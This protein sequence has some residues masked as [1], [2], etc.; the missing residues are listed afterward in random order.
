MNKKLIYI[1]GVFFAFVFIS[2][3]CTFA[4]NTVAPKTEKISVEAN[5]N[6]FENDESDIIKKIS[7]RNKFKRSLNAQ[8]ESFYK[9]YNRYSEK[10]DIKKLR[11]MYSDVFV[12]NDG[13]DKETLFKMM[14]EASDAYKNVT[15]ETELLNIDVNDLYAVVTAKETAKGETVKKAGKLDDYGFVNSELVYK[16]YLRKEGG[17]WKITA[18][19]IIS[20]TISL[21]YGEA[22]KTNIKM[23]APQVIPAGSKYDASV[24]IEA[25]EGCFVV[26][27]IVNEQI[28][29]P[30]V[31]AK[32]VLRAV[33]STELARVL[34]ANTENHN[35]YATISLG[36]T[37]PRVELPSVVIDMTGMAI[38]MS[39][40]NVLPKNN[41]IKLEKESMDVKTST[42]GK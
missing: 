17:K 34:S 10:N 18:A 19:E 5:V 24:R 15:Y 1:L 8:I 41:L 35:E 16:N 37:R 3:D 20:E 25:P 9:K 26:G 2:A 33:K 6:D 12:N 7:F 38:V 28:K 23:Y 4:I 36:I 42:K 29:Y 31:D 27:S 13:F 30:Q 39:R 11:E 14:Q 22:K 32:D 21:K 40:V